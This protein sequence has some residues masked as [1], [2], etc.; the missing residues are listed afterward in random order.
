LV[1]DVFKFSQDM[2]ENLPSAPQSKFQSLSRCE[3]HPVSTGH[4]R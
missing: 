4:R 2:S 3:V 1:V